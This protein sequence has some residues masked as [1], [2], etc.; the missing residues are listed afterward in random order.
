MAIRH[1]NNSLFFLTQHGADVADVYMT[2]IYTAQL[3]GENPFE[4][5]TALM[6]HARDVA[7]TPAD[8]LPWTFRDTLRRIAERHAANLLAQAA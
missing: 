4:Y 7:Q 3:H 8:W 5:L 1:R 2:L 6:R